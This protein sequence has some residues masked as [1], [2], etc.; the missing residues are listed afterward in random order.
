[1]GGYYKLLKI[2]SKINYS[3]TKPTEAT[4]GGV[5]YRFRS[6]A[7]FYYAVW[8]WWKV[9]SKTPNKAGQVIVRFEYE[10]EMFRFDVAKRNKVKGY[11]PDFKVYYDDGTV[12]YVEIK[13]R[14]DSASRVKVGKF[15]E[16]AGDRLKVL[17]TDEAEFLAV[18]AKALEIINNKKNGIKWKST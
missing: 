13:G 10:P 18:K 1:M 12:L 4:I 3:N 11:I 2:M 5:T 7:E 6:R 16:I 8:L 15:S 17:K 9:V 14:M